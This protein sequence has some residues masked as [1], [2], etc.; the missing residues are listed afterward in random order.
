MGGHGHGQERIIKR[1][2][3][4]SVTR[5]QHCQHQYD[6]SCVKVVSQDDDFW[7]MLV[8]CPSC[9]HR[10]LVAA[11]VKEQVAVQP[12]SDLTDGEHDRFHQGQPVD[13]D[14]VL[15]VHDHLNRFDGNLADLFP[16]RS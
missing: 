11:I 4:G 1:Y 2:V 10:G 9:R 7:L 3:L 15:N 8:T 6:A 13:S 12:L 16:P 14:D 5:C